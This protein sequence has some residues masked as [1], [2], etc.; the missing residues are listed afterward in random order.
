MLPKKQILVV[1]K[2]CSVEPWGSVIG[3]R[4]SAKCLGL[5]VEWAG[6]WYATT[7]WPGCLAPDQ[8]LE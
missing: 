8:S 5:L 4:G 7:V 2:L 6:R 3:I 1:F